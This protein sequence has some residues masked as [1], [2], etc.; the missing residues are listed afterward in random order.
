[1]PPDEHAAASAVLAR[2]LHHSLALIRDLV[3]RTTLPRPEAEA[4]T[5]IELFSMA[6][7]Y[8]LSQLDPEV[9]GSIHDNIA[10]S[11]ATWLPRTHP[12]ALT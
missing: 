3:G 12:K 11:L 4:W 5:R 2:E 8:Y 9:M 10:T 6:S 7:M 1:M